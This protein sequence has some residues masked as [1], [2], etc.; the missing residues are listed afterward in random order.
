M[1]ARTT[2]YVPRI[3]QRVKSYSVNT[4]GTLIKRLRYI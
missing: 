3:I 2:V 1:Y 4:M